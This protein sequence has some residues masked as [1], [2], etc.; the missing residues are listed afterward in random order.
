MLC[1]VSSLY[2]FHTSAV[3]SCNSSNYRVTHGIRSEIFFL[4]DHHEVYRKDRSSSVSGSIVKP[5]LSVFH[6]AIRAK[7]LQL[8][9]KNLLNLIS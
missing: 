1:Y 3:K 9:D 4:L 2:I 5:F 6:E 7:Y 8:A